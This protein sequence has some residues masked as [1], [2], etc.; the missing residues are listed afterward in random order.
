LVGLCQVRQHKPISDRY[1][2]ILWT[3]S[4]Y[5]IVNN[6]RLNTWEER[7]FF[8]DMFGAISSLFS[9]L[10]FAGLIV[11]IIL[12]T[13]QIS[14]Q[15][16]ELERTQTELRDQRSQIMLQNRA[17]D[18]QRFE[19]TFFEFLNYHNN[20]LTTMSISVE[21][22]TFNAREIFK[23]LY[24][25]IVVGFKE[26]PT[27]GDFK[28]QLIQIDTVYE[29][30]YA[31]YRYDMDQYFYGLYNIIHFVDQSRSVTN[32][33]FYIEFIRSQLSDYEL[34]ILFYYCLSKRGLYKFK[35]LIENHNLLKYMPADGVVFSEHQQL[36]RGMRLIRR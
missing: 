22:R 29:K 3:A 14:L 26:N 1:I 33:D 8:G 19:N 2:I 16:I 20:M 17:I 9:G 15:N 6:D 27:T 30:V 13:R 34:F 28:E 24:Q 11:S 21:Q 23:K 32:K 10:A 7:A 35:P 31:S 5:F 25:D 12:Q 36:Y 4:W 18:Q